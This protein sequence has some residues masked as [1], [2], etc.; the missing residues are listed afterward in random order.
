MIMIHTLDDILKE[1]IEMATPY[2][3]DLDIDSATD[4]YTI[5]QPL[6]NGNGIILE[7]KEDEYGERVLDVLVNDAII[8][9]PQIK[10]TLDAFEEE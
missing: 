8:I 10:G 6:D 1:V 3:N 2:L 9:L 7:V 5:I 4:E